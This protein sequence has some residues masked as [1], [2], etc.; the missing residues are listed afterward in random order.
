[1]ASNKK[2]TSDRMFQKLLRVLPFDFRNEYGREM[3]QVFY[4]QRIE[5]E[6]DHGFVALAKM[7]WS[8]IIDIFRMAPREHF[9]VL[10]QDVRYAF[11]M[12]S[13]NLGFSL[14]AILILGLGIGAN[15][16]I[17][18]VV[19]SVLLKPLPYIDGDQLVV[20]RH[21][22]KKLGVN[23][24]GFSV[25]ELKDFRERNSTFSEIV[26]FHTMT[27]TLLGGAEPRSVRTGVVS[28]HFFDVM[29]VHPLM[30]RTFA[31]SDERAGADAVLILSYEFWKEAEGGD[32]H[33]IG[34]RY[35]MNDRVHTVIGVLPAIP[36]YPYENDIYMP[37]T[38]C[39][40]RSGKTAITTRDFRLL[41]L[42]A[43]LKSDKTLAHCES[44]MSRISGNLAKD[45]P[46]A[47]SQNA[48]FLAVPSFLRNDLTAPA[49]PMILVLLFAAI[50]VLL[51]AC[52]NV[53]NL[54][55]SRMAARKQELVLRSALG[56]GSS[57]LFRQLLT[58]SFLLAMLAALF[59]L[60][61]A[62]ISQHLLMDF[63]GQVTPR[64]REI[65]L[66][67]GVLAFTIFCAMATTIICGSVSALFSRPDLH[68]GLKEGGYTG[69]ERS[70]N[71]IRKTLIVAQVAFSYVL[72]IGA[73]LMLHSFVKLSQVYPGFVPQN[74]LALRI[75]L[76]DDRYNEAPQR[77]DLANRILQKMQSQPGILSVAIGSSFPLDP[78]NTIHSTHGAALFQ[79]EGDIRPENE[80]PPITSIRSASTEYFKTLGISLVSGRT[81]K[82]S[83]DEKA[84]AVALVNRTLAVKRWGTQDPIGRR[85]TFDD[86]KNWMTIVGV[87]GDVKEFGLGRNAP[88]QVY[89]PL[90]QTSF[91]GSIIVRVAGDSKFVTEQIR[92]AVHE[93]DPET[94]IALMKTMEQFRADSVSSPR[95]LSR[96]FALFAV[97]ALIIA[98]GGIASMLALWVRQ[99][100]REIGIRMALGASPLQILSSVVRQGFALVLAGLVIGFAV[101]LA[102]SH[103]IEALLFQ[104]TPYDI[105]TYLL[106]SMLLLIASLLASIPPARR[107]SQI[108]PQMALRSE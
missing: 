33:I 2:S 64:A 1:M 80:L 65:T 45:F 10:S 71:L 58:E 68:S 108:D 70:G 12:M 4:E 62:A 79:V 40:A 48:G 43:R 42:F 18:S 8:T 78:V 59:G 34:K 81:F 77:L 86:G 23:D 102:V 9:S 73:G 19:N 93:V 69:S 21:E 87:V 106:I 36:Q 7:W 44:D 104:V 30:G 46:E 90:N 27:F 26:E 92:R 32:P 3:E 47:Y 35:R 74:V 99:R 22:Q 41:N 76:N 107:A 5:A 50:F 54:M 37:T 67:R 51:I 97:V 66:D 101:A 82:E 25:S 6:K 28:A 75:D 17:F 105:G 72:L 88:Y 103:L 61:L 39:P 16:A 98:V 91:V 63:V 29:G 96:L 53:A 15:S 20:L 89:R 83:D 38:S 85:I 13:K 57:R 31:A 49:R 24:A 94:P 95:T 100:M 14:S 84:P 52:A 11:R 55:L 56:A 60:F